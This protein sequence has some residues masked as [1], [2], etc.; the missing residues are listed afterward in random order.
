MLFVAGRIGFWPLAY[1]CVRGACGAPDESILHL[2]QCLEMRKV[3]EPI[4]RHS[5]SLHPQVPTGATPE[6]VLF[7]L[8]SNNKTS[9]PIVLSLIRLAWK[10]VWMH[11]YEVEQ[12]ITLFYPNQVLAH[13]ARRLRTKLAAFEHGAVRQLACSRGRGDEMARIGRAHNAKIAPFAYLDTE[14][15]LSISP[16]SAAF[17]ASHG[18][19]P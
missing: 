16:P 13:A 1:V 9:P 15:A 4:R 2:T 17:L 8:D 12:G 11:L 3:W 18:V 7:G 5:K 10:C 19:K 6:F 14:G